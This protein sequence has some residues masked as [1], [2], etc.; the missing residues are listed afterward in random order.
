MLVG[1]LAPDSDQARYALGG[2]LDFVALPYYRS[3][4][5]ASALRAFGGAARRFWRALDDVDCVWLLGPHPFA[6][7]FAA[8]AALRRRRVVLGV[9]QEFRRYIASRHPGRPLWGVAALVLEGSFRLLARLN[10][11]IVVGPDLAHR[12]RHARALLEINVSLVAEAEVVDPDADGRDYDDGVELR[13]LSV[14]RLETEKN[15]LLLADVLAGLAAGG[16]RWRLLVCGEGELA[17]ELERRLDELGVGDRAEL[18]GYVPFGERL[19]ELYRSSHV[20]LHVSLTEGLPQVLLEGFA[21]A[22]PVVATDVGG[23]AAAV[24]DA[25]LADPARR[26]GGRGCG[27]PPSR[28]GRRIARPPAGRRAPLRA[29]TH[30]GGRDAPGGRVP[31]SRAG[32]RGYHPTPASTRR[33]Q[34]SED[35][36]ACVF[37]AT[38]TP[39]R[40][41]RR[42]PP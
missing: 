25:A 38:K 22:T 30:R 26:R 12:Y 40:R 35:R 39:L 13:V 8:I 34:K 29:R 18:L 20:L 2:E 31:A 11:V 5:P 23:V 27:R 33:L 3:L 14:G 32:V 9:R 24:G 15:P 28:R 42:L 6:V 21:A 37:V 10:G 36:S 7:P 17:G 16:R 41:R 1:R 4:G 19:D